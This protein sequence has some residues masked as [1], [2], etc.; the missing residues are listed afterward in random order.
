MTHPSH[1]PEGDS[2]EMINDGWSAEDDAYTS[3]YDPEL[4]ELGGGRGGDSVLR[5]IL[6]I[7]VLVM[8]GYILSDWQE[9]I[10]YFF[11]DSEPIEVGSVTAFPE[12]RAER[13]DWTPKLEHNRFVRVEG[14]P[15]K[16]SMNRRYS[17]FKLVG[18]Q[19]YVETPRLD[20]HKG[21]MERM[22]E[23]QGPSLGSQADR[24]LFVGEGRALSLALAP[25]RYAMLREY[26]GRAYGLEFCVGLTQ[27]QRLE[28]AK[29]QRERIK[30]SWT[31][32]WEEADAQTRLKEALS[33]APT[34]A[35]LD[36]LM[37]ENPVCVDAWVIQDKKPPG[38]HWWYIALGG[39][40]LGFMV[41]D[42]VFLLR[43]FARFFRPDDDL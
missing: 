14:I 1:G 35:Q 30:R 41:V 42:F 23:E 28:R 31:Q 17:Y 19:V 11:S 15:S 9:E 16:R 27:G 8:A 36:A 13:K 25:G 18:G 20:A 37:E 21:E 24:N 39:L 32:R 2:Q 34:Q 33:P 4:A 12:K 5:P 26:Y 38:A 29:A 22:L 7:G 3:D 6:M 43:W 40:F 10:A